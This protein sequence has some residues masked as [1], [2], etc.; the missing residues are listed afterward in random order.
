M[1]EPSLRLAL[2]AVAH[3]RALAREAAPLRG[4]EL[5]AVGEQ[6]VGA[7]DAE[8]GEHVDV[9]AAHLRAHGL[10]LVG[11]LGGVRV[12]HRAE[13]PR[14]PCHAAQEALRAREDEARRVRVAQAAA[15]RPVPPLAE[16][17]ALAQALVG[18][19]AQAGGHG[20]AGVHHG[21]ARDGSEARVAQRFEHRV[22]V[23]HGAHVEHG[24]GAAAH[25]LDE[26][27][28]GARAQRCGVVGGLEGPDA[29][30]EPAEQR[31]VVG[32]AAKQRLAE[33][34]VGL[35]HAGH[36]RAAAGVEH[37]HEPR[38]LAA[39]VGPER[40]DAPIDHEHV[41]LEDA[42]RGVAGDER[43]AADEELHA[44]ASL[45]T[46]PHHFSISILPARA[47]SRAPPT[48]ATPVKIAKATGRACDAR[49]RR[50]I[51]GGTAPWTGSSSPPPS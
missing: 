30:A 5:H 29:L 19:L 51:T 1:P 37:L 33:V 6:H 9:V 20:V 7:R 16:G 14:P 17:V 22:V 43:A 48:A 24:G 49:R 28:V 46:G 35:H 34:H 18:A 26:P 15:V 45:T 21:F 42:V 2:G 12:D 40:A 47:H 39:R 44:R 10:A 27:E 23:V 38:G 11:V 3:A 8:V 4:R 50:G 36:H 25:E 31:Q 41:A 13:L 32:H